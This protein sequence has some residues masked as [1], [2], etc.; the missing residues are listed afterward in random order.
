MVLLV[1]FEPMEA[2]ISKRYRYWQSLRGC[3]GG[4]PHCCVN[5]GRPSLISAMHV[6]LAHRASGPLLVAARCVVRVSGAGMLIEDANEAD[7]EAPAV[8][9][10]AGRRA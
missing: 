8:E 4:F 10:G 9:A 3:S 1:I 2:A 6:W 7:S 5:S